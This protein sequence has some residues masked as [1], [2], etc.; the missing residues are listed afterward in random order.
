MKKIVAF[1]GSNSKNS[2]NKQLAAFAA[3]Q[4]EN[5]ETIVLDL[6]EF[7]L[8]LYCID[9]ENE[10]GIPADA[11]RL[12]EIIATADGLI[13]SL[14]EHNGSYS[15][16]FKNAYDWLSRINQ[17]VWKNKPMF[18]MATSPGKRGGASVLHAAKTG[19]PH[20]GGNVIA[21]FSLPAFYANFSEGG[22]TDKDLKE[23]FQKQ[24][25]AFKMAI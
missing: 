6:N 22:I 21:D 15:A 16:A 19:F 24:V 17:K 9:I 23:E 12:D 13:I 5:T 8:P 11:K 25:N 10:D 7:D 2:I 14:A 3:H 18:L 20:L 4:L 1:G